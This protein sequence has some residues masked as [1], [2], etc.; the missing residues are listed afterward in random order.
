[1]SEATATHQSEHIVGREGLRVPVVD[2]TY[3]TLGDAGYF[4]DTLVEL[5]DLQYKDSFS[6]TGELSIP[7]SAEKPAVIVRNSDQWIHTGETRQQVLIV[8][9]ELGKLT[10]VSGFSRY[11]GENPVGWS[12]A[13]S[14]NGKLRDPEEE[15]RDV[16][17]NQRGRLDDPFIGIN[18][19][20]TY[21]GALWIIR[22]CER[23]EAKFGSDTDSDT[24]EERVNEFISGHI[25]RTLNKTVKL[26]T[27]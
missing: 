26:L 1:M 5:N 21:R 8:P 9:K 4:F 24:T 10:L 19:R 14:N 2:E 25:R 16:P 7:A 17:R 12:T 23:L 15:Y 6:Q 22:E 27:D 13:L 20:G 18:F 3:Q 11:T